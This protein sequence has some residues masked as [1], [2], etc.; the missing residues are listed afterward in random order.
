VI[1]YEYLTKN[2]G[3]KES[4]VIIFGR[5]MGS[6]P[7]TYLSSMYTPFCLLLMS[8][9]TCI[10]DV[11]KTLLGKLSFLLMPLVHERF[12]NIDTIKNAKCP[13]FILH[14]E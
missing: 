12:R 5:S 8:P 6:G 3:V 7:S 4:D 2:V 9:Y 11:A 13:V 1:V 14:G 10:K